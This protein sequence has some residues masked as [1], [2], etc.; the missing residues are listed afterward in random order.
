M[1]TA[2]PPTTTSVLSEI[3]T[4]LQGAADFFTTAQR[5]RSIQGYLHDAEGY[6]LMLLA[7]HGPA[8]GVC[9]EIGSFMG[10]STAFLAEGA[11]RAGGARVVAV[12]H[13]EGSP[14]HQPGGTHECAEIAQTGTTFDRFQENLRSAGLLPQVEPIRAGS[15]E[16]AA[17]WTGPIRLLFIDG[18]H[19]YEATRQDFELWSPHVSEGGFVAFH[20][21]GA[22]PGVTKFYQ[23][24]REQSQDF[25]HVFAVNSLRV[26]QRRSAGTAPVQ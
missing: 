16:A 18:D 19:S 11:R 1:P 24:L 3:G 4:R 23:Q 13:F 9:L 22:W 2:T 21:V 25:Q 26:M 6:L 15:A 17:D 14:E 12:D 7:E 5:F 20:D 10:R 8:E